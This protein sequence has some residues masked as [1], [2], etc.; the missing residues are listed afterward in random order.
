M[1]NYLAKPVRAAV[2]KAMLEEYLAQPAQPIANIQRT[3]SDL[4]KTTIEA[5]TKEGEGKKAR[6]GN[7]KRPSFAQRM[8]SR[9]NIH[10]PRD[11]APEEEKT[12]R[13][14]DPVP[15]AVNGG[16]QGGEIPAD[17]VPPLSL[18][19]GVADGKQKRKRG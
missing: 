3:A 6:P 1:N 13:A 10:R 12:P 18:A 15:A 11:V 17:A 7:A 16:G 8:Q 2:L 4:A 9:N 14:T 5:S 19:D